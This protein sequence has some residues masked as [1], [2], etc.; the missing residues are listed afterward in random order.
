MLFSAA[1]A[2]P[3]GPGGA[4]DGIWERNAYYGEAQTFDNCIGH[5]P[6]NG[7][8]HHHANPVCLRA[9]LNDNILADSTGRTG[10]TYREKAAPWSHSP[11]LGWAYD[12][13]PI[14][15]PYGYSDPTNASSPIKRLDS[16]YR[17]RNITDRTSLPDWSAPL[18]TGVAQQLMAAQAGPKISAQFPL[19]RY[20]EDYEYV[21]GLGDLDIYNGRMTITPEFPQGTYAYYVTIDSAG[22]PAFPY[23]FAAQFYGAAAGGAAQNIPAAAQDYTGNGAP[24]LS[25]WSTKNAQQFAQVV[26][27]TDPSAG[28]STTW[29]GMTAPAKA[30]VQRLRSTDTSVYVNANGLARTC[31]LNFPGHPRRP[32]RG[33][34]WEW[35]RRVC[36]S[37][38]SRSS[39]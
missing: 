15:G 36:G 8:Y 21:Q 19:G 14:Y 6:G 25:S 37:T 39:M 33:A 24:V 3:P 22:K 27:G 32:P 20:I 38:A 28:P 26:T 4:G 17:L 31:R 2:Q 10:T 34:T 29:T 16:S 5:Q 12:G 30:D 7:Q 13:Y 18:H 23:I 1:R 35:G 9:Q 11:I